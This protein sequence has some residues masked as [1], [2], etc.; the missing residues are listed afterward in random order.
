MGHHQSDCTKEP[1][2]Y[3]CKEKGHMAA[4]CNFI[5]R[6]IQISGFGIPGQGFYS[7]EILD[8]QV[9]YCHTVGIVT[10]LEGNADK[11]KLNEKLR[12]VVD[13]KWNFQARRMTSNEFL[14]VSHIRVHWKYFLDLLALISLSTI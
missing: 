7:M 11:D 6:K 13:D 14:V 2:C 5:K 9:K 12:L 10:V 8:A 3:K 4:E 1:V